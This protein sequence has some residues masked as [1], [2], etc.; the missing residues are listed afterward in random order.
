MSVEK[1]KKLK[2]I[3]LK[4]LGPMR[5]ALTQ[6]ETALFYHGSWFIAYSIFRVIFCY[7]FGSKINSVYIKSFG[8]H[9]SRP[10]YEFLRLR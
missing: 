10:T 1:F 2:K 5:V 3:E 7:N 8:K 4:K 6:I 9:L